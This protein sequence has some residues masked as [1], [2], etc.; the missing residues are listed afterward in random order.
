MEKEGSAVTSEEQSEE[1]DKIKLV[2]KDRCV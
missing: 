2:F 1:L